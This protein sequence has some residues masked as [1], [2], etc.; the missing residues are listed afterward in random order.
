MIVS[1]GFA[2]LALLVL[3]ADGSATTPLTT[4]RPT[5]W[6]PTVYDCLGPS[7]RGI[8]YRE[9]T[10]RTTR[11]VRVGNRIGSA[12]FYR[13]IASGC[14][15]VHRAVFRIHGIAPRVALSLGSR[16]DLLIR[17]DVCLLGGRSDRWL[18]NCLKRWSE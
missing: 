13:P 9:R 4:V 16:R 11:F 6:A 10:L 15:K 3:S 12:D 2:L 17:L 1:A 7:F 5:A 8:Q 14:T 18:I